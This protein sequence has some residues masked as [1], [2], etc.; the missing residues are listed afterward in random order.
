MVD[1]RL[2]F[3]T[4]TTIGTILFLLWGLV[5]WGLQ[6][7][8]SYLAHT[9]LCRLGASATVIDA[10]IAGLT[11][12]AVALIAPL[13]FQHDWSARLAGVRGGEADAG[14]LKTVARTVALLSILAALW[15]GLGALLV[16]A[17][18]IGR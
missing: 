12:L 15:T 18:V 13:A 9:W 8:A 1:R 7:S 14:H 16:D 6:F 5:I 11:V 2:Q 17:C 3:P 10:V 4:S